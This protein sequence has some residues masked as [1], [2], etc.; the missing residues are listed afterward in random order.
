MIK[1]CILVSTVVGVVVNRKEIAQAY[2]GIVDMLPYQAVPPR[3]EQ[4]LPAQALRE[5]MDITRS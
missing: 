2:R 5:V 4:P 3:P 1:I